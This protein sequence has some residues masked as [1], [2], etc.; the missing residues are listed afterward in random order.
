LLLSSPEASMAYQKPF[1][2][3]KLSIL[4]KNGWIVP[5]F[6]AICSVYF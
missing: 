2:K 6:H 1:G 5:V 4:F 3:I